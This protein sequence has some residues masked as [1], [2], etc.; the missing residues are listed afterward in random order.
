MANQKK[1]LFVV[2]MLLMALLVAACG[3]KSTTGEP[4]SKSSGKNGDKK[5]RIGIA[6]KTEVQPRWKFDMQYMQEKADEL[7]AELVVQWANDD[8]SKQSNQVE[9]L[10]SQ[11]IDVLVIVPVSDKTGPVVDKAKS[12]GVPVIAYDAMIQDSDIDLYVTRNNYKVGELQA[13][14]ALKYTGGKGNFVLLKGDPATTVAQGI[15]KAYEDILKKDSNIKIVAE[16]WHQNWSTE[17]ALKTAEDALSA[18][19][20]NIQAF[21]SSNDGMAMGIA[22]AVKGRNLDGKVFISGLDVEV[23]SARLIAEGIQ[24]MSVWTK[25]ADGAQRT[26]E[27]AVQLAKGETPKSDETTNNGKKDVPTLAVDVMEVNKDN[28]C[29]FINEIAPSGWMTEKEVFVNVPNACGK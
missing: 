13:Q 6:M 25:L 23:G 17:R 15:A 26:I 29:S 10:L 12:A 18:Q 27:A 22:Q 28:L 4:G 2:V 14:A 3:D 1:R 20:D 21:I 24:T 19:N 16:Q 5:I 7:G 11:G 9:N 8:V